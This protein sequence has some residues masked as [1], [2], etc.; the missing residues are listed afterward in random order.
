MTNPY[1][2]KLRTLENNAQ[3]KLTELTKAGS[4]SFVSDPE[5]RVAPDLGRS[6]SIVSFFGGGAPESPGAGKGG[7]VSIV[8][9]SSGNV[10][11]NRGLA[12]P[13]P[14]EN[15][16]QNRQNPYARTVD[17]LRSRC[18]DH[19]PPERWQQVVADSDAFI[20]QWGEQAQA[21]GWTAKDLWG[22][23]RPPE[24]PPVSY[25]RLSR[26]DETGLVWL[27]DGRSVTA[28]S[29]NIAAIQSPTGGIT[30]YRKDDTPAGGPLGDSLK[31]FTFGGDD[32]A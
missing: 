9:F 31:D 8:S 15:N 19:V 11:E 30:K 23:H 6:V 13:T 16:R 32:V 17:A 14:P 29:S 28:L 25:S 12:A 10:P 5:C 2:D 27:L 26:Y 18:P 3:K 24:N 7:S 22:L 20:A 4:V 21:L 1:L